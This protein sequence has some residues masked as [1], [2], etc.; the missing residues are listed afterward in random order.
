MDKLVAYFRS[1]CGLLRN[2]VAG[3][4]ICV[5][6]PISSTPPR[7]SAPKH[8]GTPRET[9]SPQSPDGVDHMQSE[10]LIILS[11]R[12]LATLLELKVKAIKRL[13]QTALRQHEVQSLSHIFFGLTTS[14][15][16]SHSRRLR[17]TI[18]RVK[19]VRFLLSQYLK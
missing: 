11:L 3:E 7:N 15:S 2:R 1:C 4:E 12:T 18:W 10:A 6:V 19:Q 5:L 16:I 13:M 8:Q 9:P 17:Y 14:T